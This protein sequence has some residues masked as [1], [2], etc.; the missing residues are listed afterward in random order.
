MLRTLIVTAALLVP[1][2]GGALAV[3]PTECEDQ[4][5][6]YPKAWKDTAGDK[7]LFD[8]QSHYAD[9]LRIKLGRPDSAGRVLMS[10]VTL[11]RGERPAEDATKDV[12]R[13]W[14]D[15][16]QAARLMGGKYLAT[17]MRK[18]DSCWIR[19]DLS[20]DVVFFMDNA[21]PAPDSKEA[22]SFYNKAPR[23]SVFNGNAYEC[24]PSR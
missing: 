1:A 16:E 13:I 11:T 23:I 12:Y 6:L 2:A 7:R 19:G 21:N 10:L 3:S 22:G 18:E 4:R 8:C 20:G 14:L 15:K 17:I 9:G 24:A 5:A